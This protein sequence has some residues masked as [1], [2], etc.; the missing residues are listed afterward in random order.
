MGGCT[1]GKYHG[2]HWGCH[3]GTTGEG[4]HREFH[5]DMPPGILGNTTEDTTVKTHWYH[6][7]NIT[8]I[9]SVYD[10]VMQRTKS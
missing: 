3:V 7:E 8:S 9:K 4:Y 10:Y 6:A 5:G 2:Y 1:P